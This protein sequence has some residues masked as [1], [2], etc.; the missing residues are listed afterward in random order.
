MVNVSLAS[1]R[2]RSFLAPSCALYP[3]DV[4]SFS[5][6]WWESL[7]SRFPVLAR[8]GDW[9]LVENRL[10]KGLIRLRELRPAGWNSA[11]DWS[12]TLSDAHLDDFLALKADMPWDVARLKWTPAHRNAKALA[13]L[14]ADGF[15]W[16]ETPG[17]T[18]YN[19]DLSGGFEHYLR[20]LNAKARYNLKSKVKKAETLAPELV[21]FDP[22]RD[23][24]AFFEQFICHHQRYWTAKT[25]NSYL[26]NPHEQA[27]LRQ[28]ALALRQRG[29]LRLW[30]L[31]MAGETANLSMA[32]D[33]GHHL[34]WPLVINTGLFPEYFPGIVALYY[35]LAASADEGFQTFHMGSGDYFYKNQ[36]ATLREAQRQLWIAN[37]RSPLGSSILLGLKAREALG[38]RKR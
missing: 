16:I 29:Q 18:L 22:Q 31:K 10:A 27:F 6:P 4:A 20:Q 13:R 14:R 26:S 9:A 33:C 5:G 2:A 11:S 28:W 34:Y 32:I 38:R 17:K 7:A 12:Q 24:D 3:F 15:D 8:R 19:V 21:M 30:G 35:Y 37:P 23:F 25:G 36:L 1:Q